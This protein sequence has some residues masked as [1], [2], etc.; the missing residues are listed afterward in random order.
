MWL[1]CQPKVQSPN[2]SFFS[3]FG[4]FIWLGGLLGQGLVLEL[5]PGLNNTPCRDQS[6]KVWTASLALRITLVNWGHYQKSCNDG[7]H[8]GDRTFHSGG[9]ADLGYMINIIVGKLTY[10]AKTCQNWRATRWTATYCKENV[11]WQDQSVLFLAA[12]TQLFKSLLS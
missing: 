3:V 7:H 5:G 12:K 2:H 11:C 9:Q 4:T 8:G 1:K 6:L 10:P